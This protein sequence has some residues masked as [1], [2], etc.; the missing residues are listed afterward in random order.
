MSNIPKDCNLLGWDVGGTK[1]SAVVASQNGEI[2]DRQT[3]PSHAKKGPETMI[4]DFILHARE[5]L[6][7]YPTIR[8]IGVSI[9]GPLYPGKGIIK[10][11]PHLPGWDNIPLAEILSKKLCLSV[12]VEHDAAACLEAEWLWGAAKG[13]THAIYLTCGTGCG[14][15]IMINNRILRGPD[16]QTP[17]VGHVRIAPDGPGSF[18]KSG[19]VES[20]C[21]GTGISKLAHFMFPETFSQPLSAKELRDLADAGDKSAKA[22]LRESA[23]RTGQVCAMLGDIFCPQIIILGSMARYFPKWWL[24]IV[25]KEFALEALP[26]NS[27]HTIITAAALGET[28]QDL[29]AVAPCV[30]Q[31]L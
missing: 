17:E 25:I 1:S 24:E 14:A 30:F 27:E 6:T 16:G 31:Q 20:F 9:G 21:S 4:E 5:L 12:T 7:K 26:I 8:K 22:V 15:G 3:W 19:C 18:G 11:P 29:S 10:S 23:V 2:F 28:L 13:K